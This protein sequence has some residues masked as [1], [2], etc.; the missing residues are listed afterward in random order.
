MTLGVSDLGP[1]YRVLRGAWLSPQG[2]R[3]RKASASFRLGAVTF[4]VWPVDELAKD[5][6]RRDC[7]CSGLSR[8][9]VG[10]ELP[11]GSRSRC[12]DRTRPC[13]GRRR[14]PSR[15]RKHSGAAMQVISPIPTAISGRLRTIPGFP[16]TDE[17]RLTLPVVAQVHIFSLMPHC[18]QNRFGPESFGDEIR[19]LVT[20]PG[21]FAPLTLHRLH[22]LNRLPCCQRQASR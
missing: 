2:P 5:A 16:L 18:D 17:G 10:V 6:A 21:K 19:E 22:A 13:R 12:G 11:L 14:C 9:G 15:R 8:R 20:R 3:R 4:A 1:Q 7:A